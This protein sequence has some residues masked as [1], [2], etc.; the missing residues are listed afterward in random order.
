MDVRLTNSTVHGQTTVGTSVVQLTSTRQPLVAGMTV[1]ALAA[2]TGKVY[3]GI[4]GV[5]TGNG[6][7]LSAGNSV[8]IRCGEPDDLYAISDTAGQKVCWV[9]N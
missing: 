1:K 7:E 8:T 2:N 3:V 4:T 6:Y 9:A 5:T